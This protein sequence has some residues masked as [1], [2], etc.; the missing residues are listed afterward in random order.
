LVVAKDTVRKS[1]YWWDWAY[2]ESRVAQLAEGP[3]SLAVCM[4][5]TMQ[6][7]FQVYYEHHGGGYLLAPPHMP[8]PNP[9][10]YWYCISM[11]ICVS[12]YIMHDVVTM[13]NMSVYL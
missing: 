9:V 4:L 7:M 13:T 6:R 11:T 8:Q 2:A 12:I 10:G 1:P 3:E 5:V